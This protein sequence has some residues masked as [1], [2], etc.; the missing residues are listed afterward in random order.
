MDDAIFGW[1]DLFQIGRTLGPPGLGLYAFL[2][3]LRRGDKRD[4]AAVALQHENIDELRRQRD[5]YRHRAEASEVELNRAAENVEIV[6][7]EG[8]RNGD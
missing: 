7:D 1:S 2:W 5:Y 4:V 6:R 3:L 8:E